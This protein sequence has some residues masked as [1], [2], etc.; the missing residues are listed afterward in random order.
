MLSARRGNLGCPSCCHVPGCCTAARSH[1]EVAAQQLLTKWFYIYN[2]CN[3][4]GGVRKACRALSGL[5]AHANVWQLPLGTS[6]PQ[7]HVCRMVS[8]NGS[9]KHASQ[10]EPQFSPGT[11]AASVQDVLIA[12][13]SIHVNLSKTSSNYFAQYS[14][15]K[16]VSI[17]SCAA[18]QPGWGWALSKHWERE[19]EIRR[20][21]GL[22]KREHIS[23][24][25]AP[26]MGLSAWPC[27][28]Y[29]IAEVPLKHCASSYIPRSRRK[30]CCRCFCAVR[31]SLMDFIWS[32][33]WKSSLPYHSYRTAL[34]SYLQILC[35]KFITLRNPTKINLLPVLKMHMRQQTRLNISSSR[36]QSTSS[37]STTLL[38]V[39]VHQIQTQ[40]RIQTWC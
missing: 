38:S 6:S 9:C 15:F 25:P 19:N 3:C 21:G 4:V 8:P 18:N 34:L 12:N 39:L 5:N 16:D 2:M 28:Q 35:N 23:L 17:H 30:G 24:F 32:L 1:L 10:K 7:V 33:L 11:I 40:H 27:D 31:Q 37:R 29:V 36:S 20:R 13:G 14:D 22:T 26:Y